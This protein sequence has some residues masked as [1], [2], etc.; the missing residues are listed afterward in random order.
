VG[1]ALGIRLIVVPKGPD[2]L[3]PCK[4][5]QM[6]ASNGQYQS[7]HGALMYQ[8]RTDSMVLPVHADQYGDLTF[9]WHSHRPAFKCETHYLSLPIHQRTNMAEQATNPPRPRKP[10]I[11]VFNL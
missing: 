2:S 10:I 4:L 8:N 11:Q 5:K 6:K 1:F 3:H 7:Y 9:N